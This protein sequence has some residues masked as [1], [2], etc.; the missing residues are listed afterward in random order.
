MEWKERA[1][2]RFDNVMR[3]ADGWPSERWASWWS[4]EFER[5]KEDQRKEKIDAS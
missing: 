4:K 2:K 3:H 5:Q 1:E